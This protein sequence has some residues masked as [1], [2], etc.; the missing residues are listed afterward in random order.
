MCSTSMFHVVAYPRHTKNTINIE[1]CD[2]F[3]DTDG[4]L[5]AKALDKVECCPVPSGGKHI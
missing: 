1:F 5:F 2:L 3:R 4:F